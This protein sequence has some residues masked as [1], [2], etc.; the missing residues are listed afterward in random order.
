LTERRVR[1]LKAELPKASARKTA[2]H[3][4]GKLFSDQMKS[5]LVLLVTIGGICHLM[6]ADQFV[7]FGTYTRGTSQG[8]Y[9]S[10]FDSASGKLTA[11]ELAVATPNPSFLALH[12]SQ[13]FLYAVSEMASDSSQGQG[14]VAAFVRDVKTG[15]LTLLNRQLSGGSG[16]CHVSVDATGQTLLVANYGSGSIAALPIQSD[17]QLGPAATTIQHS[18]SSVHS[19]QAGPHAHFILP[20]PD[21]RFALTCD[22]GLD[23]ILV[24]QLQP[25]AAKLLPHD[26]PFATV[27]PSAGPRHFAFSPEG[28]FVYVLNELNLTITVFEYAPL[29]G[30]LTEFQTLRTQPA[31]RR[32]TDKDSA[33]QIVVHPNGKFVYASNRGPDDIAVFSVDAKTKKLQ[34]LQNTPTQGK[35]PRNFNLSPDGRWLLAANQNSDSV[36]IFSAHPG[37]G[38]LTPTGDSVTVGNPVCVLFVPAN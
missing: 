16:P 32:V 20:S 10:R 7:Y 6:S 22:L 25:T 38:L 17:G 31:D 2:C 30:R 5:L 19:R 12:P 18:G 29:T 36:V 34:R 11:P 8:I 14:A 21:N 27:T 3:S 35:T 1:R 4:H 9:V 15:Q 23:Q 26:P 28:R 24:Y 13:K 37:S 33:A